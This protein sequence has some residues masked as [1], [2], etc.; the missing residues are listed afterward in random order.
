[1]FMGGFGS[2]DTRQTSDRRQKESYA[3]RKDMSETL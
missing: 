1:M 3:C 2:F